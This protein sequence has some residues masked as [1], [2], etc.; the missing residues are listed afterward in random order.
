MATVKQN[1][2]NIGGT[3]NAT[4]FSL[5]GGTTAKFLTVS[6]DSTIDQDLS[7]A[8]TT[9]NFGSLTLGGSG[10][11]IASFST[12]NALGTSDTIVPTQKAIK[13]Y[14]DTAVTSATTPFTVVTA[15]T[16]ASVN[17]GYICNKAGT[18]TVVTLPTTAAIGSS[19]TIVAIGATFAKMTAGA[20]QTI[21]F[22]NKT[23]KTAGSI[24]CTAIGDILKVVCTT[25]NT[26]W[27]VVDSI[28]NFDV[29]I[30]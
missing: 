8:S 9:A 16:A 26:T 15:D 2:I 1:A 24:S 10:A 7:S 25:A 17:N 19:V 23:T 28:G 4:G 6:G 13:E 22:G 30:S 12:S 18:A 3:I 20:G 5:S 14:V 21:Q 29:E 27:F 11:R